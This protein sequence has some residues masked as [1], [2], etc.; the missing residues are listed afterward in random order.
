MDERTDE[1]TTGLRELDISR[2]VS[3]NFHET[4]NGPK[5][6]KRKCQRV[7]IYNGSD[8]PGDCVVL[9]LI[10]QYLAAKC[11]QVGDTKVCRK[12]V[13]VFSCGEVND[14]EDVLCGR[15][16][17]NREDL[18]VLCCNSDFLGCYMILH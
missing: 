3:T 10:S 16:P 1:R 7:Y 9:Q 5:T 14:M 18:Q 6:Y 13:S 12:S 4:I 11:V 15:N 17:L 8:Q 2:K